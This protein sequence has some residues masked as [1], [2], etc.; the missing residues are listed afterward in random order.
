MTKTKIGADG[1]V[2]YN[3]KTKKVCPSDWIFTIFTLA[4]IIIPTLLVLVI[5][6]PMNEKFSIIMMILLS[7]AVCISVF[8]CLRQLYKCSTTEPGILPS[9][10]VYNK[11]IPD[12]NKYKIDTKKE[13]YAK[14]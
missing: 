14:Y 5:V 3:P 10:H 8:I 4:L 6:I 9:V 12:T 2:T 11:Q 13:Y 1:S 7:I